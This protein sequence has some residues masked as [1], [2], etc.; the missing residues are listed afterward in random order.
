MPQ[1]AR[2]LGTT[3][4]ALAQ[5]SAVDQLDYVE[6]FYKSHAGKMHSTADLYSAT[7]GPR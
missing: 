1:T 4:D 6:K 7:S 3:T 5:M 2:A